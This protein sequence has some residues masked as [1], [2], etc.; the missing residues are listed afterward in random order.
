VKKTLGLACAALLA[1]TLTACGGD[2]GGSASSG[3]DYCDTLKEAKSD[4][5]AIDSKLNQDNFD[6]VAERAQQLEDA[7]P[8][9]VKG[10]WATYNDALDTFTGA[11]DDAGLSIDDLSS[12]E[13]PDDVDPSKLQDVQEKLQD[14]G[15]DIS[16]ATENIKQHAKTECD[17]DFGA[18]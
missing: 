13:M 11:L 6:K 1:A 17:V 3:A 7:A 9:E 15:K 2:D 8:D 18:K 10:D 14:A 5:E 4:L 12:G 16:T